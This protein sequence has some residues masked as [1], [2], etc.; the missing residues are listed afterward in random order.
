MSCPVRPVPWP[1]KSGQTS[2]M[3]SLSTKGKNSVRHWR[4]EGREVR[5]EAFAAQDELR[6]TGFTPQ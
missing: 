5:D 4:C 2:G 6:Y 3:S 1:D